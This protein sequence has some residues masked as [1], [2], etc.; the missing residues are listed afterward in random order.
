M[1]LIYC[2]LPFAALGIWR[3]R[4]R[5]ETWLLTIYILGSVTFLGMIV[6]N[7]GALFRM[8][9]AYFFVLAIPIAD[10]LASVASWL[11]ARRLTPRVGTSGAKRVKVLRIITRMNI[12]GPALHALLLT[13]RLDPNRYE[14][15][16][17][18][19]PVETGEGDFMAWQQDKPQRM[20]LLPDLRRNPDAP[21]DLR[22][23]WA[24]FCLIRKLRPDIVHTHMAKAGTLGRIAAHLAG[25]PVIVHTYHGHVLHGYFAPGK[26]RVF[27]IIEWL[28][29]LI[30]TRLIAV[31]DSVKQEL[32]R[33]RIGKP[34]QYR[35]IPLGL[36]VE[37]YLACEALQGQLRRELGI[38]A[39]DPLIGI[40]ARLAPIKRHENLI[41]AADEVVRQLPNVRFL[42][43]GDGEQRQVLEQMTREKRLQD[44]VKFLGWRSDLDRVYADCD[45][46]ALTSANEGLPVSL[47]EA[48][49]SARPVVATRVG[50]VPDLVRAGI[51]GVLVDPEDPQAFARALIAVMQDG[52]LRQ[53]LGQAARID[54]RD[55]FRSERLVE[56]INTLYRE[57]V[58]TT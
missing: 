33:L 52:A 50:G 10:G 45:V 4:R 24:L 14:S 20:I 40:V 8:R 39:T 57:L 21:N 30:S 38:A 32:L 41:Q 35:I 16:L 5:V 34:S 26:E 46:V 22:A 27:C 3:G 7:V 54:V 58:C 11:S 55:R 29:A 13:N 49:A 1:L 12:G 37:R 2:V 25:V 36:S 28:L 9:Y 44:N 48:M 56:D 23:L 43:V 53:R 42:L 15:W 31:S 17:V 47:I 51:T 6:T 19:G 18:T